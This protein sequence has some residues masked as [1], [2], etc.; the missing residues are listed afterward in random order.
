MNK[1]P[2]E[3]WR[4]RRLRTSDVV[5][6]YITSYQTTCFQSLDTL[7]GKATLAVFILGANSFL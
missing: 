2:N 7:L 6:L 4:K 1:F 3:N 5:V